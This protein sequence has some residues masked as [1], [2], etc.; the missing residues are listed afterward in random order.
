M[1]LQAD[2][3]ER[4]QPEQNLEDFF[5]STANAFQHPQVREWD[6]ELRKQRDAK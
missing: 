3:Y 5:Q 4:S 2:E 6:A 1:I